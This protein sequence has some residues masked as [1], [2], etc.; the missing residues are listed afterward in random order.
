MSRNYTRHPEIK[1]GDK[2]YY[3]EVISPPF[4]ETHPNGKKR[5]KLLC[6][7]ICGKEKIFRY[8]SFVCKNEL[9]RAKSCGCK[10]TYRNNLNSQKRRK[11]ESVYRYI[12]EQYQSSAKTRSIDF[13][14]SKEEYVE[15]VKKD[16]FYCGEEPPVKQP[17]RGKKYYVG[18]PVPYNGIDRIDNT[19]GYEKQ[20]CVP[21][22]T[23]CNYMKSDMDVS[24]F[25]KH[26][27][28][29][30][31][32]LQKSKWQEEEGQKINQLALE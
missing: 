26:I 9:D 29:I 3:L 1:V 8:D 30:T 5:K 32:H 14:L 12:Y 18:V 11:P 17:H 2:F 13:N 21:C 27:L 31:N 23:K 24:S 7:C 25:T 22:C 15:L 28:K 20:N 10:H 19:K 4:F 6:K 16:C